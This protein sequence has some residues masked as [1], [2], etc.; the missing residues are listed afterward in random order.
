MKIWKEIDTL[1]QRIT[2][3][4]QKQILENILQINENLIDDTRS[5]LTKDENKGLWN[6][7]LFSKNDI[8]CPVRIRFGKIN[9]D[10]LMSF[11]YKEKPITY[12]K[13]NEDENE[14]TMAISFLQDLLMT[15]VME[16]TIVV[17]TQ[18]VR[19][20]YHYYVDI[21]TEKLKASDSIRKQTLWWWKKRES[22]FRN[23]K[24]W[25]PTD[26]NNP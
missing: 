26:S 2:S 24:S 25:I 4:V 5:S 15:E 10:E 20:V 3:D 6:I 18:V 9:N 22:V 21:L 19:I 8:C 1:K 7:Q 16:E 23:Y 12:G 11:F 17:D 14:V 13:I